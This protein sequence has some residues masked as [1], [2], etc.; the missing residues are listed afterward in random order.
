MINN[1]KT[2]IGL[3]FEQLNKLKGSRR[4]RILNIDSNENDAYHLHTDN[5]GVISIYCTETVY[6]IVFD[7]WWVSNKKHY[8]YRVYAICDDKIPTAF[9]KRLSTGLHIGRMLHKS[10]QP[11]LQK[12]AAIHA[13][14]SMLVHDLATENKINPEVR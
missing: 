12:K 6:E 13:F 2:Q 1:A 5:G 7:N 14:M 11:S 4:L 10:I 8:S 3:I 9:A